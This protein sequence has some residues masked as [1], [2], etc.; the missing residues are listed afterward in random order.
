MWE[1]LLLG[2]MQL[3]SA[4]RFTPNLEVRTDAWEAISW[5][6]S[7]DA[8]SESGMSPPGELECSNLPLP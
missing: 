3:F 5:N 8:A 1:R 7:H 4:L 2:Y 6:L